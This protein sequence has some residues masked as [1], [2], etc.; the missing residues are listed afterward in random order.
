MA[1]YTALSTRVRPKVPQCPEPLI[2]QAVKDA[3]IDF[4]RR[5]RIRRDDLTPVAAVADQAAYTL[6]PPANCAIV[7]LLALTYDGEPLHPTRADEL[8]ANWHD[9]ANRRFIVDSGSSEASTDQWRTLTGTPKAYYQPIPTQVR[10]VPIPTAALANAIAARAV[11]CPTEA[12]TSFDDW[13]FERFYPA[14]VS[15]ALANLLSVPNKPW[16]SP[17]LAMYHAEIFGRGISEAMGDALREHDRNDRQ[18][19]R[20]RAWA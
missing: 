12:S 16:T 1:D 7:H 11:V 3:V 13:V 20:V 2:E 18:V 8:D 19:D 4:Y 6:T 15:G 5:S 14:L 17:D 9:L 10:L